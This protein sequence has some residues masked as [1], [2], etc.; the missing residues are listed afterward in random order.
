[1]RKPPISEYNLELEAFIDTRP[2]APTVASHG[3]LP[4]LRV[5]VIASAQI[6]EFTHQLYSADDRC[7][8]RQYELRLSS[9]GTLLLV[10]ADDIPI[11]L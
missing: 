10:E 5:L 4:V 3:A 6:S 2:A 1:M 8:F 11:V 7:F 9:I